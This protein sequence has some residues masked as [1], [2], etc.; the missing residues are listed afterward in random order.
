MEVKTLNRSQILK[1]LQTHKKYQS[2]TQKEIVEKLGGIADLRIE[3]TRLKNKKS[4]TTKVD[5]VDINE[6]NNK[7]I[8]DVL[9]QI[10]LQSNYSDIIEMC[11][12]NK[13]HNKICDN[14]ELWKHL[15]NRDFPFILKK[16]N[17]DIKTLKVYNTYKKI[18]ELI[19]FIVNFT[20]MKI[21]SYFEKSRKSRY[22][23]STQQELYDII[24]ELINHLRQSEYMN[25]NLMILDRM[26]TLL[27][28]R[29]K[30]DGSFYSVDYNIVNNNLSYMLRDL[31]TLECN[32]IDLTDLKKL[33]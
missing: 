25:I 3:L 23:I 33:R 2:K 29:K 13:Q 16:L 6:P 14:D 10:F 31:F 4:K 19:H 30:K 32:N 8:D 22:P 1:E 24:L 7:L 18:Y 26:L 21:L 15:G 17:C 27:S 20:L 9:Y 28:A 12:V 11:S 5:K